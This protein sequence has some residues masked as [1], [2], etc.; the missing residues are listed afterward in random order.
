M[1]YSEAKLGRVFV[2]RLEDG[3]IVHEV[4]EA[5]AAKQSIQ[6]ASLIILGGADKGSK[7]VVGPENG[8]SSPIVPME[9]I[10]DNV[11]EV[12]GTGTI[13]P[14]QDGKPLL[15]LH[16]ACGRNS[17]TVTGCIRKGVKVWHVMEVILFELTDTPARRLTDT[18]TG[19]KF[20]IPR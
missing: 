19:F 13:F 9:Y 15:H 8:R 4:I 12:A 2:I 18:A 17:S 11:R 7:L 6:A 14:D 1:K 10:L 20:L 3:E 5:F 16:M